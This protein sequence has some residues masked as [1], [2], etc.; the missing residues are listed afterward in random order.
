MIYEEIA[1]NKRKSWLLIFLFLVVIAALGCAFGMYMENVYV[2]VILA[3]I[4]SVTYILISYYSGDRMILAVSHARPVEK[5]DYPHLYNTVEGLSISAGTPMPKVYIIDDTAINAFATGRDP[6]HASITVTR[7]A[8]EKLK[9]VELEGVIGHE[10]SHIRNYDI[11]M[12]M[13]TVVLVGVTVLLS[14]IMLRSFIYGKKDNRRSSNITTIFILLGF[15]LAILAPFIA[16]LI[17]L[18]ISRKREFLADADGALL[19]RYPQGLADALKII[20]EDKEPL[21]DSANKATA[22][23]YIANPLRNF[24]GKVNNFF[25]T[26]PDIDERIN[27][28]EAM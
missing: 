26:H 24:K 20:R 17:Q 4:I 16:K 9:R 28:L 1:S 5:K 11:R 27:R 10:M 13:L 22:H 8:V 25:N 6:K 18:A 3:V 21:V 7:G 14:D 12:M 15:I 23:L 19:T 2:G